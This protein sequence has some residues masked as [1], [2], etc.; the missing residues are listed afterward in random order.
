[1]AIARAHFVNPA[2]ARWYHCVT[3]CVRRAFLL[4][5]GRDDRKGWIE[6]RLAELGDLFAIA[7]GGFAIMN[8]HLHVLLRIDPERAAAWSDEEVV[9]RSGQTFP[10]PR[11]QAK[12]LAGDKGVD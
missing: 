2:L 5:E 11:S 12:A 8:N 10:S 9:Q 1:M 7:V 3:R 4:G 6:Q